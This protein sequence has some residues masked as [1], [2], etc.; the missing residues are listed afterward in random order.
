[1]LE[2]PAH[3]PPHVVIK[4]KTKKGKQQQQKS[5]TKTPTREHAVHRRR[6]KVGALF[7]FFGEGWGSGRAALNACVPCRPSRAL[8]LFLDARRSELLP[9]TPRTFV[10]SP[11][12]ILTVPSPPP[13]LDRE[14]K[15]DKTRDAR[16][17][18]FLPL[19]LP[20]GITPTDFTPYGTPLIYS[21]TLDCPILIPLVICA[22]GKRISF[23]PVLTLR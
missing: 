6:R 20:H 22:R 10:F 2:T 17:V 12:A 7:F 15:E 14:K 8:P 1:M 16:D 3:Q 13:P 5:H 4:K 23:S 9:P 19:V 18:A 21:L 11:Y